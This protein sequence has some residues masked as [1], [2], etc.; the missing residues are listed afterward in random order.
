MKTLLLIFLFAISSQA[1]AI[2]DKE[3]ESERNLIKELCYREATFAVVNAILYYADEGIDKEDAI[4]F[5]IETTGT[6]M[7]SLHTE[8][9]NYLFT[10]NN[11]DIHPHDQY[12]LVKRAE[13]DFINKCN[14]KLNKDLD[15]V[16]SGKRFIA[17]N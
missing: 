13:F 6:V 16:L 8:M 10:K 4:Y 7:P 12:Y 15:E 3:I 14:T 11:K 1:I 9:I 17:N 2:T 5:T